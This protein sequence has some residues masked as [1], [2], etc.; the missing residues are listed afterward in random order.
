MFKN[1]EIDVRGSSSLIHANDIIRDDTVQLTIGEI[2]ST[3]PS[4]SQL[5]KSMHQL[6]SRLY[7]LAFAAEASGLSKKGICKGIIYSK[8]STDA[9][10]QRAM[11]LTKKSNLKKIFRTR[12]DFLPNY[13]FDINIF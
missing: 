3:D 9:K 8:F 7:I 6:L 1:L 13:S 12:K 2:K 10:K 4:T 11:K 5:Q